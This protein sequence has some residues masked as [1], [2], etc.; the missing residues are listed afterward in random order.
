M[1]VAQ[2]GRTPMLWLR[3]FLFTLGAAAVTLA[4]VLIS[5]ASAEA[6]TYTMTTT[7]GTRNWSAP[8]NWSGGPAGTYPGQSAA[9]DTAIIN[10][11]G[12]Y[13][14]NV[15]T[16]LF[17]VILQMSSN[18][19]VTVPSGSKLSLQT[20]STL[21]TGNTVTVAPGGT[22]ETDSGAA[23]TSFQGNI[24]INGG[25]FHSLGSVTFASGGQLTFSGGTLNGSGTIAMDTG[26]S[27]TFDGTASAMSISG[28]TFQ[29]YVTT[30]YTSSANALSIDSGAVFLNES[31][32]VF[33]LQNNLSINTD[34]VG[35]PAISNLGSINKSGAGTS[36]INVTLNN[37][38]TMSPGSG[39]VELAGGGTHT[40]TFSL[41]GSTALFRFSGGSHVLNSGAAIAASPLGGFE[42]SGGTF[43]NNVA[44]SLPTFTHSGGTISGSG[45]IN[46]AGTDSWTGGTWSAGTLNLNGPTT[47]TG[48]ASA[49]TLSGG[50]INNN[51]TL[52]YTAP[53]L[54]KLS[55][56]GGTFVNKSGGNF[57]IAGDLDVGGASPGGFTNQGGNLRKTAGSGTATMSVPI[58]N[59]AGTILTQGGTLAFSGG[60]S[61]GTSLP[62]GGVL[63][64]GTSGMAIAVTGGTL[65]NLNGSATGTGK[66]LVNGGTLQLQTALSLANVHLQSGTISG[67]SSITASSAFTWDAGTMNGGGQTVIGSSAI[68]NH[69]ANGLIF[70]DNRTLT[71]DGTFNYN[72]GSPSGSDLTIANGGKIALG[73]GGTMFIQGDG[74][75][76]SGSGSG[77]IFISGGALKK[78]G[79]LSTASTRIDV[80]VNMNAGTVLVTNGTLDLHGGGTAGPG[81]LQTNAGAQSLDISSGTFIVNNTATV[82]LG[83]PLNINGGFLQANSAFGT[84]QGINLSA[85]GLSGS[86][87]LLMN[88]GGTFKWTGGSLDHSLGGSMTIQSGG[89]VTIDSTAGGLSSSNINLTLNNGANGSWVGNNSI[90]LFAGTLSNAG[91]F[92]IQSGAPN[93]F[94]SASIVNTGTLKKTTSSSTLLVAPP[95]QNNG[96]LQVDAGDFVFNNNGVVSHSG[97]FNPNGT[98][99]LIDFALG[100]H[101]L[102]NGS[103]MQGT[104]TNRVSGASVTINLPSTATNFALSLGSFNVGGNSFG[105]SGNTTWR[106]GTFNGTIGV[107]TFT[108]P[109]TVVGNTGSMIANA[110]LSAGSTSFQ[111]TTNPMTINDTFTSTG[112]FDFTV[113]GAVNGTGVFNNSGPLKKSAGSGVSQISSTFNNS[114]SATAQTGFLRFTGNGTD[115][116]S[117]NAL[118]GAAVEFYGG[119]RTINAPGSVSP[120]A[121]TFRVN[122][123]ALTVNGAMSVS[124]STVLGAGTLTINSGSGATTNQLTVAGGTLNG[125]ANLTVNPG[126]GSFF[127][128]GTISGSGSLTWSPGTS[129]TIFGLSSSPT[130]DGRAVTCNAAVSYTGSFPLVLANGASW[131]QSSG[132]FSI[133]GDLGIGTS[134]APASSISAGSS[135]PF[136]KT[137]GTGTSSIAP[138]F[139]NAGGTVQALTGTLDFA[140]GFTQSS[141]TTT[142][143]PGTLGSTNAGGMTFNGGSLTG[144]GTINTV[145]LTNNAATINPSGSPAGTINVTGGYTM[146]S[147]A[148]VI[149][150][151]YGA[152]S[153]DKVAF[154]GSVTLAGTFTAN[155][156]T[157]SPPNG[158]TFDVFTFGSRTGDFATKNLP[159]YPSGGSMTAS[160]VSGPPQALRLTAVV[161]QADMQTTQSNGGAN[162]GQTATFTVNVKNN[163]PSTATNVS[164]TDSFTNSTFNAASIAGGSCSGTGP[165]NCTL[166]SLGSGA[167]AV[168]TLTLNVPNLGIINNNAT[169]TATEFDPTAGNNSSNSSA[170]VT[171]SADLSVTSVTDL[172]DPVNAAANTTYTVNIANGGPDSTTTHQVS[173]SA[174]GGGTVVSAS[175][176]GFNCNLSGCA[177][178]T[179]LANGGTASFSVVV[180]APAQGGSMSLSAAI[181]ATGVFDPNNANNTASQ[182]TT[183]TAVADLLVGKTLTTPLIAGQNTTYSVTV[184]NLGPSNAASVNVA[185]PTPAGLTFVSNSGGCITAFPCSLGTVSAGQIVTITSTYAVAPNA[186]GNISNTA[187]A[188]SPTSDPNAA[189]NSATATGT[190]GVSTDLAVTKTLSG[191][192]TAGQTATYTVVVTNNGPSVATGVGVADPTPAGLTFVSNSGGCTTPYPCNIGTLNSGQSA[193]ITS[194]YSVPASANGNISN[195]AAVSAGTPDPTPANNSATATNAVNVQ[196]DLA[197]TK[198]GPANALLG[199]NITYSITVKNN[200]PSDSASGVLSDPTPAGLTFVSAT[201][202]CTSFPCTLG[203][204][205][206]GQT[207]TFSA[208]YT[209]NASGSVTNTA[210]ASQTA[211]TGIDPVTTNNSASVTTSTGCP[212]GPALLLPPP[213]AQNVPITGSLSWSNTA[214]ASYNVYFGVAGSGCQSLAGNTGGTSFN[215]GQLAANTTYEWRIESVTPG[216]TTASSSC[217]TFSTASQCLL[218]PPTLIAPANGSN[219]GSPVTFSWSSVSGAVSYTV[220]ASVG[221][222]ASQNLGTTNTTTLS[223]SLGDGAVAW[224]V[225]VNGPNNCSGGQSAVGNFTVCNTAP[226]PSASVVGEIIATQGYSVQWDAVDGASKYELDEALDPNFTTLSAGFPK[227]VTAT[228][229]QFQHSVT[230]ATAFYYRVRA[231]SA[232]G[233]KFGPNSATVRVVITPVPP[234]QSI[235]NQAP[236]ANAPAGSKTIVVQTILIPG[237]PDGTFPFTVTIDQPW[238][239]VTP[240]SGFLPPS[241]VVLTVSADP[242]DLPNGTFTGTITVAVNA[243]ALGGVATRDNRTV[244]TPIS[245]NMVTPVS[246]VAKTPAISS[247][248]VIPSVGHLDGINS[249]WQ[250][251]I[252]VTNTALT[253]AKYQLTFTPDDPAK[254]VKQ[255]TITADPGATVA[256]DDIVR[257]WYGVGSLGESANGVLQIAPLD[258][259]GRP[260]TID[261]SK[262]TTVASSRTYNVTSSGTLGQFIPA[263]PFASFIGKAADSTKP[264]TILG[265]QQI[266]ESLAYRT[267]VGVV[268]AAGNP[269]NVLLTVFDGNGKKLLDFPLAL[270]ANEQRQLNSFLAQNKISI[271]D[272]R[273]EAK[274]VSGDGKITAYASVVDNRT[275]DPLLVS[276]VPLNTSSSNH[277]VLPGVADLNVGIA[278][279]RTDMRVF[280]SGTVPQLLALTFYQQNNS[281]APVT[282]T[283]TVNP[284]ETKA[285][286]NIVSSLFNLTNAGGAVH[287]TSTNPASLVVTGRT[288]NQTAD[289]TF[290]QFIPAVTSV[291]AAAKDGKVLNILQVETSSRYRTNIGI[292]E[293]TGKGA[294]VEVTAIIPDSKAAPRVTFDI[295]ANEFFQRDILREMGLSNVYNA[296]VSIKVTGG[297]GKVAAYGSV[298]DMKTQDPTYVPAQ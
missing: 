264:A 122:G 14:V 211:G 210:T 8:S 6:A 208:T 45:S 60:G 297:E 246:A 236:S 209:V 143:G 10:F 74:F 4:G 124:G 133:G 36:I 136:G 189:N 71:V 174:T 48:A 66:L 83:T 226:A 146:G 278:S 5:G 254:G 84:A 200:G 93:F 163:G 188:S 247:A 212:S 259:F 181:S 198:T 153:F 291:D 76:F 180:K 128:G 108:G 217:G 277:Y 228:S 12:I 43:Q 187:S 147:S 82:S 20:S 26:S 243:S 173:F 248:L 141:G 92:D 64:T 275:G 119:T 70:L 22:F 273:I 184:K 156:V 39:T 201:G 165:V 137:G 271:A 186:S 72:P 114:G 268:E 162:H 261:V 127:D 232:C 118:S 61:N 221:G 51:G 230:I 87:G 193:T 99:S 131:Q 269:A 80:P 166:S 168:M 154:S 196:A 103:A 192:L 62:S 52:T 29:N 142:A 216:C 286:D 33:N 77:Q 7:N 37:G 132:S 222:A 50:T 227:T 251:D 85:G 157:Y 240:L 191:S 32:G 67:S 30:N 55:V 155:L 104:G 229:L 53:V 42:V 149:T 111:S 23:I 288:Y 197:V 59:D 35:S 213:G 245:V 91:T 279:W 101:T 164:I 172:P 16:S 152:A 140:G 79:G 207:K 106:G 215:F 125:S 107:I 160:Y 138:P 150:D 31:A 88:S 183:V 58:T 116:G 274:V 49:M 105:V 28:T 257:N 1:Q 241:G 260:A 233:Q 110:K 195:T 112:T 225:V 15:D 238:L 134:G 100:T 263:I 126:T 19:P 78:T 283:M 223:A 185:D 224:F 158:T 102:T 117:F 9:G 63:N 267:N 293:V 13:T 86:A 177:G 289:G 242:A 121:G 18:A 206:P 199:A 139:T 44:L 75:I 69:G 161:T 129:L 285:L 292:A 47:V 54:T 234:P 109:L 270:K 38:G 202:P 218:Q 203:T 239:T 41:V 90:A 276:G 151:I 284:G 220:F 171:P 298:I 272:G 237:F 34:G 280:N 265:L 249:K 148:T 89:A 135:V 96:T 169:V 123:A 113:D 176:A 235:T 179:T 252:R 294:T 182:T 190:V 287:I 2:S 175:G 282:Q 95:V 231:F 204:L 219:I 266:A 81:T 258:N 296:R 194:V 130:V 3:P 25:T 24:V 56:S 170:N 159:T 167:T 281:G 21:T 178:N 27:A 244:T 97:V 94:G 250:S 214:A 144:S 256:L 255:T 262:S 46:V 290:G 205:T 65:V 73:T 11:G 17:P 68:G 295:G 253:S 57:D 145:G 120:V 98:N 115:T 40:G